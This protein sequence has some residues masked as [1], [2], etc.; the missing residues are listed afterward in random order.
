VYIQRREDSMITITKSQVE[1]IV[2]EAIQAGA[3]AMAQQLDPLNVSKEVCNLMETDGENIIQSIAS[4][5][6]TRYSR[7][8]K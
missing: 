3:T 6:M 4:S 8:N 2:M 5:S 7:N 1:T